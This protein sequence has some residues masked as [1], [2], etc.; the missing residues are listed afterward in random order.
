MID[1]KDISILCWN[2]RGAVNPA[3]R[4]HARELVRK[5]RPSLVILVETHS[6]FVKT[7]GFWRGLGYKAVGISEAQGHAG[8]IWVLVE[9]GCDIAISVVSI[10]HQA[11]SFALKKFQLF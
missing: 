7:E 2:I 11:V 4:R 1:F 6:P 10:F 8:G 3:G 5:H 9:A